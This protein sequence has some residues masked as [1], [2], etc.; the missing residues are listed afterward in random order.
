MKTLNLKQKAIS[1]QMQKDR[2]HPTVPKNFNAY[3]FIIAVMSCL[4]ILCAIYA[5]YFI[6]YGGFDVPVGTL[7][8][9]PIILY[10]FQIVAECYGWQYARQIVWCNFF[11]NGIF[12]CCVF[13]M[14]F[15]PLSL[16]THEDLRYSY[17]HLI[18]TMWVSSL[19]L[20][21]TIFIADYASTLLMCFI[22][23]KTKGSFTLIRILSIHFL[24]EMILVS[25][26]LVTMPYNGYTWNETFTFMWHMFIAR[27]IVSIT[28]LPFA[29]FI[30]W[31]IQNL[32]EKVVTF[33]YGANNWNIFHWNVQDK[34]TIQFDTKEWN[35]LSQKDRKKLNFNKIAL[36][37]Y[38]DE[39]LGIKS[40]PEQNTKQPT[41]K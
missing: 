29:Y 15:V 35:A 28:I 36:D 12:T 17:Q 11:V 25:S 19:M 13:I 23:I 32:V 27:S 41:D 40:T 5:R 39:K 3:P 30:I 8:F 1:E 26:G 33:E 38:T 16:F 4:Q 20:W 31:L 24:S 22:R 2:I 37:F 34:S 14:K 21:I 9:T 7:I 6:G 10:I 18:D